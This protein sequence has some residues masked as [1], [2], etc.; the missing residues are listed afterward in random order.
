MTITINVKPM[1]LSVQDLL[2]M[3]TNSAKDLLQKE[4][5]MIKASLATGN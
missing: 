1:F 4:T 3:T 2:P 5:T